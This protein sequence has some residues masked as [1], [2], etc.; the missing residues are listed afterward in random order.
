MKTQS[1]MEL[2]DAFAE[3]FSI[4][5]ELF[6][7]FD[8]PPPPVLVDATPA[9]ECSHVR[10]HPRRLA[11]PRVRIDGL[12]RVGRLPQLF[13]SFAETYA[14]LDVDLRICRLFANPPSTDCVDLS[15]AM[16]ADPVL[17]NTLLPLRL[18]RFALAPDCCYDPVC[19]DLSNFDGDDCPIVRL[20]HESI[21]MHDRIDK[22]EVIFDSF[23]DLV[24]AVI[25]LGHGAANNRDKTN[26]FT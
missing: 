17:N 24:Q 5:D 10:W 15:T 6:C 9:E 14:W 25:D 11:A 12:R 3:S 20:E 4:L 2:L 21:L 23:R 22:C 7:P 13:E 26:G 8:R 16:F 18:V 19:F 1:D